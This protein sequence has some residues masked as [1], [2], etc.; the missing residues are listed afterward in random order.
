MVDSIMKT[1]E[2]AGV[3]GLL[4]A[5][6]SAATYSE[7]NRRLE[8]NSET[9][10]LPSGPLTEESTSY[11]VYRWGG[12]IHLFREDMKLPSGTAQQAWVYWC[13]GNAAKILPRVRQ[14]HP[15]DLINRNQ[16]T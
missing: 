9:K 15:C 14:L 4:R 2:D 10:L 13:C 7:D 11:P 5:T 16:R 1:L 8:L 6:E 12:N 3:L